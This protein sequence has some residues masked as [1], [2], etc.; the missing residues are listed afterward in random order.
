MKSLFYCLFICISSTIYSQESVLN[1]QNLDFKRQIRNVENYSLSDEKTNNLAI[2]IGQKDKIAG[3]LYNANF[4]KI[5][6]AS[7]IRLKRRYKE[8]IGY[9]ITDETTY[10][11]VYGTDSRKKFG[12]VSI[13]LKTGEIVSNEI[14]FTFD[15]EKYLETIHFENR[16]IMMSAT[17][18]NALILR[19]FTPNFTFKKIATFQLDPDDE[20]Q[21]LLNSG[22]RFDIFG[23]NTRGGI[24]KIDNRVPNR[25]ERASKEN[26]LYHQKDKV[27]I[28]FEDEESYT[29]LNTLDLSSLE[30]TTE[31]F[32][33]PKGK[34][35][36]FKNF[37]SFIHGENFFHIASS[38]DEM[39]FQIKNFDN[40]ILKEYYVAQEDSIEFKNSPIIQHGS[41][42]RNKK[43]ELNTTK[44]FLRKIT[45][46]NIG[47]SIHQENLQYQITLG[48]HA[49]IN[50][51]GGYVGG[52]VGPV[53][54]TTIAVPNGG[55]VFIPAYNPAFSSYGGY[56][57]SKAVYVNGLFDTDFNHIKDKEFQDN[58][59]DRIK[60]FQ[61][62]LKW[63]TAEDV[64]IHNGTTYFSF[65]NTKEQ[66]YTLLKF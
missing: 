25:I 39:I 11:L 61:D 22:F 10:T 45:S 31:T 32:S 53:G 38:R 43:R 60:E 4:E 37:N 12:Y 57:F 1:F 56:G 34:I 7:G 62:E 20:E 35:D 30:L 48:S 51:G 36:E 26:K 3:Y 16:M 40:T 44:Q 42:Y 27:Y 59:F 19:E 8:T 17:K 65:W 6:E 49:V 21:K 55:S 9:S 14:D 47:V 58:I 5:G 64:F 33:Y 15:G 54:G 2:V 18:S 50:S 23:A 29:I 24:T 63:D 28:T 46:G 66:K 52:P 41:A 13:D